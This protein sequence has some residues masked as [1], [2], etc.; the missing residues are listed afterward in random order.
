MQ[1]SEVRKRFFDVLDEVKRGEC[2]MITRNG[3]VEAMLCTP[4]GAAEKP[5]RDKVKLI[6]FCKRHNIRSLSLFGSV[7]R[8]DFGPSSDVDVL[9]EMLPGKKYDFAELLSMTD[10]LEVLFGRKVDFVDR[11]VIEKH[12]NKIRR[13]S[14]LE[15]AQEIVSQ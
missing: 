15:S 4:P 10:E 11:A 7:L 14:I 5:V 8:T 9:F 12:H 2:V 13:E 6:D 1:A 3:V